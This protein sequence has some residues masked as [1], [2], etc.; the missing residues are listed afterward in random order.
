ML[1]LFTVS[2]Q[3]KM[4]QPLRKIQCFPAENFN[5]KFVK[6]A[7]ILNGGTNKERIREFLCHKY[8]GKTGKESV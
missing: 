3:F 4:T 5:V 1:S 2:S 7:Q 6:S 8:E